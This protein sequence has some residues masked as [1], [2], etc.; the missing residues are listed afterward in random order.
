M[1]SIM[2]ASEM[3]A[4]ANLLLQ[5]IV[6][7]IVALALSAWLARIA[8]RRKFATLIAGLALLMFGCAIYA[9]QGSLLAPA[10]KAISSFFLSRGDYG[11]GA[12]SGRGEHRVYRPNHDARHAA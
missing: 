7:P 6:V 1:E 12:Q 3:P 10:C 4:W 9:Q 8:T 5:V 11:A 2:F